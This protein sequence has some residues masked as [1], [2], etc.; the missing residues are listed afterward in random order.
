V[1]IDDF[2]DIWLVT[3]D[4]TRSPGERPTP[5]RLAAREQRTGRIVQPQ[6]GGLRGAPPLPTGAETLFVTFDAP[7]VLGCILSLGWPLPAQ[8]LDL[9]AE[10]RCLTSGLL[11]PGDYGLEDALSHFGLEGEGVDGLGKLLVAT[12]P[13]VSVG[14]ALLRGRYAAAV[15]RMEAVGVPLDVGRLGRL[16]EG[17]GRIRDTLVERVDRDYG[18]FH[19]GALQ[20][21]L[22][23]R[24]L[25]RNRILWPR[26]EDGDLDL[27]IDAFREMGRA[28]PRLRRVAELQATLARFRAFELA[29][30][31]DGRNRCPLRPFA[32]KTGRNQPGSSRFI[33]GPA[34]WVRGLIK[35]TQG[36]AVAYLDYEQQE[37]GI[38]AALSGDSAM[39]EAYL[40][41]D[42]YLA[43]A[44]Q[45]GA[46]PPEATKQTHAEERERFK[47]CALGVQYGMQAWGL[48]ARLGCSAQ[49][50]EHLLELHRRSYPTYWAWSDAVLATA[51]R[52]GR[53]RSAFGWAVHAGPQSNPRS[54]R[55]FPLQANGAEM[56]RLACI[57][58][59]QRGV[60]VCAPLHDALLVEAPA[61]EIGGVVSDCREAMRWAS[62]QVLGG[63]ALRADAKIVRHPDRYMTD[64]GRAMWDLVFGLLDER[65]ARCA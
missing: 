29:V 19:N 57:V 4:Y 13:H 46:V 34:A 12:L 47:G 6:Q 23:G 15:A 43:F 53:L 54:L 60:R 3:F 62:E 1:N 48:A 45:A 40:S 9:Y 65:P 22:W 55:N 31:R 59:T 10:F 44:K 42:P 38:A 17:W 39:R 30:G 14:H 28:H 49:A 18:V 63:F 11:G 41:T 20:P 52:H 16:R 5:T 51:R 37:F 33:F 24:W 2:R 36:M 7:A 8:V 61:G 21:R 27:R 35:P 58:L 56:L 64:R 26:R 32:S 25:N 50:A